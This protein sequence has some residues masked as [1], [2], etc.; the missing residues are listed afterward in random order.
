MKEKDLILKNLYLKICKKKN[1]DLRKSEGCNPEERV[2]TER[3]ASAVLM[4]NNKF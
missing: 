2:S 3:S 1:L 4:K